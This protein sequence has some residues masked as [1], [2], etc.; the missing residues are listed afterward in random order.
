MR[1][2]AG[3]R[4]GAPARTCAWSSVS[5]FGH[6]HRLRTACTADV[7][8]A[9][10]ST[11]SG[12][13][14]EG[15]RQARHERRARSSAVSFWRS[16]TSEVTG[17]VSASTRALGVEDA[18]RGAPAPARTRRA[19]LGRDREALAARDLQE[20]QPGEQPGE[21]RDDD[22]ARSRRAG[23]GVSTSAS[24]RRPGAAA[25][26]SVRRHDRPV[27]CTRRANAVAVPSPSDPPGRLVPAV[28][29]PPGARAGTRWARSGRRR[30]RR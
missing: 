15:V 6:R 22:H 27:S 3:S 1:R 2:V 8:D 17:T 4:R 18:C 12:V 11:S 20:P 24:S 10:C 5:A 19:G 9:A 7:V 30:A 16:T 29:A 14:A 26:S 28:R 13:I 21:E 23:A 25:R